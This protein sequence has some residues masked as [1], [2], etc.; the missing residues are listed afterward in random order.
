MSVKCPNV[1]KLHNKCLVRTFDVWRVSNQMFQMKFICE[2]DDLWGSID[3]GSD[4]EIRKITGPMEVYETCSVCV[5]VFY[6]GRC[7]SVLNSRS[8]KQNSYQQREWIICLFL[9]VYFSLRRC[10]RFWNYTSVSLSLLFSP[11]FDKVCISQR[12][13]SQHFPN[14]CSWSYC[15]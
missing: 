6:W 14:S 1:V 7:V 11:S 9:R 15:E 10:S 4:Q 3:S 12:V 2:S 13:W 8:P 5:C